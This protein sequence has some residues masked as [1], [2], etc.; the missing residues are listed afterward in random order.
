[1]KLRM[2]LA[3]LTV[4]GVGMASFPILAQTHANP[5]PPMPRPAAG[6]LP[7]PNPNAVQKSF[8]TQAPDEQKS[9]ASAPPLGVGLSGRSRMAAQV[10]TPPA[11]RPAAGALPNPHA[12]AVHKSFRTQAPDEQQS[13]AAAQPVDVG[14]SGRSRQP[15]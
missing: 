9:S 6:A 15:Q 12:N 11:P 5:S 13:S 3:A 8:R 1:M 7:N 14:L 2:T 10:V 4:A